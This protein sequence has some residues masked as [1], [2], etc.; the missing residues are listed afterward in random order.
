MNISLTA[1]QPQVDR[2]LAELQRTFR[3]RLERRIFLK[4]I[5]SGLRSAFWRTGRGLKRSHAS[6]EVWREAGQTLGWRRPTD[7]TRSAEWQI[8]KTGVKHLF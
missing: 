1:K 4:A 3:R 5:I 8:T 7:L 2:W 6:T